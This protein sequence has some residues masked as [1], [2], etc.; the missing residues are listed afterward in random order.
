MASTNFLVIGHRY[1]SMIPPSI[2]V[3]PS[4]IVS[5]KSDNF[6]RSRCLDDVCISLF[7]IIRSTSP[8][9]LLAGHILKHP[10]QRALDHHH[11]VGRDPRTRR[12]F[13]PMGERDDAFDEALALAGQLNNDLA[14]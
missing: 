5:E 7:L 2:P 9:C 6:G 3:V 11:I 10:P 12:R 13:K 1:A 4:A 14:V 8:R